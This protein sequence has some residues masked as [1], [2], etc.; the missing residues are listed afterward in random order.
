MATASTGFSTAS[1]GFAGT[2]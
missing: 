1:S 2:M